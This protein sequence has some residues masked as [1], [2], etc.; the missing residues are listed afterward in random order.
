M[1]ERADLTPDEY[2]SEVIIAR[3]AESAILDAV[4]SCGTVQ[5]VLDFPN[6]VVFHG[7]YLDRSLSVSV[8]KRQE[9]SVSF[10]VP[11][12]LIDLESMIHPH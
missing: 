7:S 11:N 9:T 10:V 2:E 12:V 4:E 6:K 1:A 8:R 5:C 3:S